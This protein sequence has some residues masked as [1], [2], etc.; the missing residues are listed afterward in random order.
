MD[1]MIMENSDGA[2]PQARAL[3]AVILRLI[4]DLQFDRISQEELSGNLLACC[5]TALRPMYEMLRLQAEV[6]YRER[7]TETLRRLTPRIH[8]DRRTSDREDA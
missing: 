7:R 6:V 2:C 3:A 4:E 8:I 5:E 1:K